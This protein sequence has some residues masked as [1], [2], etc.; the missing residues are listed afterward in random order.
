M[1]SSFYDQSHQNPNAIPDAN[2]YQ[3]ST[4][5]FQKG[6]VPPPP[7]YTSRGA[8]IPPHWSTST[9]TSP[10]YRPDQQ[11]QSAQNSTLPNTQ[12]LPMS[13]PTGA[14][15]P[16]EKHNSS[17]NPLPPMKFDG[18][19]QQIEVSSP[20]DANTSSRSSFMPSLAEPRHIAA[21]APPVPFAT[22][23]N[24]GITSK[25]SI[26]TV[27][28]TQHMNQPMRAGARPQTE[29]QID[30]SEG[31]EEDLQDLEQI[32]ISYRRADGSHAML[33]PRRF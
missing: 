26:G 19:Q 23:I 12:H 11:Q 17:G 18:S 6:H 31:S 29:G 13:S 4:S 33:S 27:F 30:T 16:A 7:Q 1:Q 28:N 15:A 25:R 10:N 5:N 20:L 8:L 22:Q 32:K 21:A 9:S 24:S 3:S 2:D 14:D